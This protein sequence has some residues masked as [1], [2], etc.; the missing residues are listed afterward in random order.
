MGGVFLATAQGWTARGIGAGLAT[1]SRASATIAVLSATAAR[2]KQHVH[3]ALGLAGLAATIALL[4]HTDL[5]TLRA[6]GPWATFAVAVEG[7]RVV[8]EAAATRALH[9]PSVRVP[10]PVLLRAHLVGYSFAMLMPAGRT[11]AE[12]TK[13]ALLAPWA[14]TARSVGVAATNQA[15]VM[16]STGLV[17]LACAVAARLHPHPTLAIAVAVQGAT[18][19]ALGG[20]LLALVRSRSL[21]SWV[22]RR[23]PRLA[24]PTAELSD[25]VRTAGVA[26]ALGSFVFHRGV[27]AVQIGALLHAL[28]RG[29]LARTLS[30]TGASIVGTSVGVAVPGQLGAIDGAMALASRGLSLLPSQ[31]LAVALVMHAAQFSWVAAGFAVW[32]LTRARRPAMSPASER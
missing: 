20:G 30:L 18:L 10:W 6:F 32:A 14:G 16:A 7:T 4:R 15:L 24:A 9:G 27:Q 5:A 13:A 25:D 17:A 19:V 8:A 23:W 11:V 28:G 12:A 2:W 1:P 21:A 31:T 29:G 3:V 22:G 26:V